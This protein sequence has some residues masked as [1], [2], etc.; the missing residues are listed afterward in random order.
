M[1]CT[2]ADRL[3]VRTSVR[4]TLSAPPNMELRCAADHG[5][6]TT[7]FTDRRSRFPHVTQGVNFN[8]LLCCFD[9]FHFCF[10]GF[11]ILTFLIICPSFKS[12]VYRNWHFA[13]SADTI[14]R[15]SQKDILY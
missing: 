14:T 5:P 2:P 4:M 1:P 11:W 9:F 12:S 6:T 7:A 8:D 13:L 10:I 3:L 15:E